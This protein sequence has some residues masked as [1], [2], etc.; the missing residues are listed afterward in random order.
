MP[1]R[2]ALR[3]DARLA[4]SIALTLGCASAPRSLGMRPMEVP[5]AARTGAFVARQLDQGLGPVI[6]ALSEGGREGYRSLRLGEAQMDGWLGEAAIA[7]GRTTFVGMVPGPGDR[8][9]FAWRRWRGSALQ[10]WCAR[11]VRVLEANGPEG[12]LRRTVLVE[13]VLV[14]GGRGGQRWAAWLEGL[15][16]SREGWRF[17]PWVPHSQAVEAPRRSHAD[18]ELWDCDLARPAATSAPRPGG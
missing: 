7:R 12:L 1:V 14:V 18:L 10:G 17:A 8:R 16:L 11:G 4:V 6:S 2:R 3:A 9:W 13:R 5:P 15:L